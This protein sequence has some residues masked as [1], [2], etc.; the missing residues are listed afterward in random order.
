MGN[1]GRSRKA[2][3]GDDS[4]VRRQN[5]RKEERST[6]QRADLMLDRPPR[7]HAH[8]LLSC[9]RLRSSQSSARSVQLGTATLEDANLSLSLSLS[10]SLP[11]AS[12]YPSLSLC[13]ATGVGSSVFLFTPSLSPSLSLSLSLSLSCT[14]ILSAEEVKGREAHL[15]PLPPPS[16]P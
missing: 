5:Q 1:Q 3:D 7:I 15:P 13:S 16:P 9:P 2:D 6:F 12:S 8:S 11:A 4:S 10:L 14:Q